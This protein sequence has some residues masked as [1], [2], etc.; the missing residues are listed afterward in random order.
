[1]KQIIHHL[2]LLFMALFCMV[3]T[4][5]AQWTRL[6]NLPTVY[7]DTYGGAPITSKTN[8]IYSTLRYVDEQDH[9]TVYDSVQIR[10]RGNST[11]G[12]AKKPYKLKFNQKERF[13]G[14]QRANAKKWTLLANAA[15]KT[16]IR[17]A[18]TSAIGE[19]T[20]LVFNPAYKFVDLV[21]NG[22]H[23]G[24]YQI[25]DHIDVRKRR[26]N[27][28]EQDLPLAPESDI[29]GG[30][31]LEVDGFKEGN[32]FTTNR[33][34]VPVR[35]HY[36]E[37]EDI[38]PTQNTYIRNYIADF[39]RSL[40][41]TYFDDPE[42]GYRQYVDSTSL[43][44]W[45]L[46][47]EI[48]A[49]L[50]G[51]YSTY[52]YKDQADPLLYWGPVWD[53]DIAYNNDQR[54]TGT[55]EKLM[56]DYGFGQTKQWVNRMWQDTWFAKKVYTR[57]SELLDRGLVDYLNAKIDSLTQLLQRSQ[58]LNYE[59]WGINRRMYH[60]VVLYSSY[61]QYIDNLRG[62]I[63]SHCQWLLTAFANRKPIEPTPEFEPRQVY[64]RI[65]NAN[66]NK[67]IS[68]S[69]NLVSQQT[70]TEDNIDEEWWIKRVGDHFMMLNR[71]SLLA[72]NDPTEGAVG[73]STNVGTPID[74]AQEDS[75][76][77]RQLWDIIPQGTE[78][79]YNLLNVYSQ[80]IANLRGGS[81][82][83]GTEIIS[84]TN[85]E[86]NSSSKN[87]L[88]YFVATRN[89]IPEDLAGIDPPEPDD[90]ALAYNPTTEELHFGAED[91]SQLQRFTARVFNAN[92]Q[93]VG[94]FRADERFSMASLP[95]GLY[96][97]SWQCSQQQRSAK[98]MR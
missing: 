43:I 52:F 42:R 85:D 51:Y 88:W 55:S 94:T 58:E 2:L 80:H 62:F 72:L 30:Y 21:L 59:R 7:I 61:D 44:D 78:G 73:P 13:L 22:T 28:E 56:T 25:S 32:C 11:W 63:S 91:R 35:I 93:L 39:E 17:N 98:F 34:S 71:N 37:D 5:R 74:V 40:Q 15:D 36:P 4:T 54:V 26:V 20:S 86:R 69:G 65:L 97:V 60:E 23:L 79:Y 1:M 92:G 87:R 33:Y 8:Y 3:T 81:S 12:L 66:T 76:D 47:T 84:Y 53:A 27:I 24:N 45:F 29:T 67:A 50:D 82:A 70:N 19:F 49:N 41:A 77:E 64:Y 38:S 68:A 10:G 90:Y 48:S 95:H 16:L 89:A 9:V 57:Y 6:T 18:V 83:D 31:L 96:I 14:P 75:L 46:V